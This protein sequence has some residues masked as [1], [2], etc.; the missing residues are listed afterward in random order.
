MHAIPAGCPF[1]PRCEL[2]IPE[3]A[4]ALPPLLEVAPGH[5]AR[6]PVLNGG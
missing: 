4:R 2:R 1:E 6:C 5:W 3:C